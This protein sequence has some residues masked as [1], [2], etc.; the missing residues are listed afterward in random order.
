MKRS[1]I[2]GNGETERMS[3]LKTPGEFAYDSWCRNAGVKTKTPYERAQ[4]NA[5]GNLFTDLMNNHALPGY[6]R[7]GTVRVYRD[8]PIPFV[9]R[10]WNCL[11]RFQKDGNIEHLVDV[12]NWAR[13]AFHYTGHPKRHYN[14]AKKRRD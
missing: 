13:I 11:D 14:V 12:A 7:Y 6:F 2:M 8:N 5:M 10:M 9:H 3:D 4:D 1:H